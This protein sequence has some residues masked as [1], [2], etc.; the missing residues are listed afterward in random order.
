MQRED[1]GPLFLILQR[2]SPDF[3]Y[4]LH[5]WSSIIFFPIPLPYSTPLPTPSFPNPLLV[6]ILPHIIPGPVR[7][8]FSC[9]SRLNTERSG[10]Q[11]AVCDAETTNKKQEQDSAIQAITTTINWGELT[12]SIRPF[13]VG[14]LSMRA[15]NTSSVSLRTY[16]RTVWW[17][18]KEE[19][20]RCQSTSRYVRGLDTNVNPNLT[21]DKSQWQTWSMYLRQAGQFDCW[22]GTYVWVW[23][24]AAAL[25]PC[26]DFEVVKLK[27]MHTYSM[28][29]PLVNLQIYSAPCCLKHSP[30]QTAWALIQTERSGTGPRHST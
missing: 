9:H 18:E 29:N 12:A 2:H 26:L 20:G 11:A 1:F 4:Q 19:A 22:F 21:S 16:S 25:H 5:W 17:E 24:F 27:P 6:L 30:C 10:S 8:H 13:S 28:F 14:F 23:G 3:A 15:S 7:A